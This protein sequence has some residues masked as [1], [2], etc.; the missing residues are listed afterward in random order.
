MSKKGD[1]VEPIPLLGRFGSNLE[2][3]I[4]GLPNVGKSTLFNILT[5]SCIPA[6]NFPFCT[7]DPNHS[8]VAVPDERFDFLVNYHKPA[9]S[10]PAF[11]QITDIAGLVKGA[12]EGQGLGN[13]FLS[14]IRAVDAIFHVVRVFEDEE[15]SHVEGNVDPV[16]DLQIIS[17]ELILKD[18]EFVQTRYD[19]VAQVVKRQPNDKTKKLEL[20][21]VEKIL[22]FIKQKKEI[23]TEAWKAAEV[24]ILNQ[25]Q[26]LTAKPVIYL[27]NMTANDYIKKKNK[28]LPK[29]K[30]WIDSRTKEP[31]IPVSAQFEKRLT[32]LPDNE[33]R[34]KY[35]KEC[36][37]TSNLPKVIK[38]GYHALQLVHFFTAGS[39]EVKCWTI[40]AGTKAPQGAGKIHTDFE[41]GFI[42]AEIM[43]FNDFKEL[44]SEGACRASG[45]YLQK[46]KE[47]IMNDGDIVLFK[48]NVSQPQKKK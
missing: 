26:L 46:G 13:A 15:V 24:E 44:G 32:E 48:F 14:H 33:A 1:H 11:L 43:A 18:I 16:R 27:V 12:S 2:A 6:E 29:I 38:T 19:S 8:R 5:N 39:D 30:E 7:I 45:K 10:V 22:E 17:D 28:W 35:C 23:R 31:L 9:S 40:R 42:C 47:Y 41:R 21:S 4:V 37:A 34:E 3:G 25:M 36:G 20:E